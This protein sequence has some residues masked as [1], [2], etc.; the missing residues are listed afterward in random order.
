MELL[1]AFFQLLSSNN[2][3]ENGPGLV[4]AEYRLGVRGLIQKFGRV[5]VFDLDASKLCRQDDTDC[6][7]DR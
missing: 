4:D 5:S 2:A 6:S 3:D 7:Y 1:Q